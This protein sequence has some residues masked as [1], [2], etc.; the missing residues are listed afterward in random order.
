MHQQPIACH[1]IHMFGIDFEVEHQFW[2][3]SVWV[4]S[5]ESGGYSGERAELFSHFQ[6]TSFHEILASFAPD[7]MRVRDSQ[8]FVKTGD[9]Q[10]QNVGSGMSNRSGNNVPAC[11]MSGVAP[12][13]GRTRN[14]ATP[15]RQ[16]VAPDAAIDLCQGRNSAPLGPASLA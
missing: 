15:L 5:C 16:S 3:S 6:L 11:A 2:W 7:R 10:I 4:D 1:S 8:R 14:A 13:L 12:K 9:V